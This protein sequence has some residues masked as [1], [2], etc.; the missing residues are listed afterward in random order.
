MS[1]M[2]T[3]H[4]DSEAVAEEYVMDR[5]P[6]RERKLFTSHLTSCAAC[7]R[8]VEQTQSYVT[9]MRTACQQ[10]TLNADPKLGKAVS[11]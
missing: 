8:E 2:R 7:R 9:A 6:A 3:F 10:A 5:M 4:C 1:L 11:S